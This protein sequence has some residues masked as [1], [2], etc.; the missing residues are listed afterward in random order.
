MNRIISLITMPEG[1]QRGVGLIISL[2]ILVL[3]NYGG[4]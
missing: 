2:D 1:V 3:T 4:M